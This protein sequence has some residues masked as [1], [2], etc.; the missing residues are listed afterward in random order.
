MAYNTRKRA[1]EVPRS[2]DTD[3][4]G[5][6]TNDP[7]NKKVKRAQTKSKTTNTTS[8]PVSRVRRRGALQDLPKMPL[9]IIDEVCISFDSFITIAT[10]YTF[11]QILTYMHLGDLLSLSRTTKAFRELVCNKDA[12]RF[13][14]AAM[15]NSISDG[16]PPCPAWLSKPAYANLM[17][18]SHCHVSHIGNELEGDL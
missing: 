1:R 11:F 2:E 16:L 13:W 9:D 14:D 6:D 17:Y 4:K 10:H 12:G 18:S 15:K 7:P 5:V 8:L 3:T